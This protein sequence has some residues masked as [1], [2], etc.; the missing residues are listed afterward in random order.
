MSRETTTA[1][2]WRSWSWSGSGDACGRGIWSGSG[3]EPEIASSGS[4]IYGDR[5]RFKEKTLEATNARKKEWLEIIQH[6]FASCAV[7]CD[8]TWAVVEASCEGEKVYEEEGARVESAQQT[9]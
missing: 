5:N 2:I 7:D 9:L 4:G 1:S 3:G 8:A 6:T